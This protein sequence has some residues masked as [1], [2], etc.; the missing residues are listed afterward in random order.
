MSVVTS[1]DYERYFMKDGKRYHHIIN[2]LTG[3]PS[4]NAISVTVISETALIAD[5]YSTALFL[6]EPEQSLKLAEETDELEAVVYFIKDDKI[7]KL[8][9]K[10][11]KKY[12]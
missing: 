7:E 5:A 1:G 12:H 11:F 9:T 3:Y 8:E 10:G 2:P 6:L 4:Q